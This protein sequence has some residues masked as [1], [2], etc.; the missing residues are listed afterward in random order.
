[1]GKSWFDL[2]ERLGNEP[3]RDPPHLLARQRKATVAAIV[4]E[5]RALDGADADRAAAQAVNVERVGLPRNVNC[6]VARCTIAW[7]MNIVERCGN[8][9][10]LTGV[11]KHCTGTSEHHNLPVQ[12]SSLSS[13]TSAPATLPRCQK[14]RRSEVMRSGGQRGRKKG[15]K[16]AWPASLTSRI[17]TSSFLSF[18]TRRF[19]EASPL[20]DDAGRSAAAFA[21]VAGA[22]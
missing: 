13:A 18:S 19:S 8:S 22:A 21:A 17:M 6:R 3:D 12:F 9:R 14:A 16:T 11:V 20:V 10:D 4:D 7:W 15:G 2:Q 5:Q 1:M